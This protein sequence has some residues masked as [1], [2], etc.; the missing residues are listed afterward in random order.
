MHSPAHASWPAAF[1]RSFRKQYPRAVRGEK[2]WLYD[3]HGKQYL[4]LAGSAAVSFLGHGDPEI[5]RAIAAQLGELEF[6]HSSQFA[7]AVAE[8]FAR[9][10]LAFA[11]PAFSG[12]AVYFT[13]GGSEAVETALKLA[14]QYQVES[15]H[16]E[17]FQIISRSQSYHGATFGA[18][19]VS[20]NLRR[21]QPYLPML[22]EFGHINTPYCY[23]CAYGGNNCAASYAGELERAIGEAEGK[24]AAFICEP[25]SGATL[26]AVAPPDG[27]LQEVRRICDAHGLLWIA[28]EVMTGCGRTGRNFACEHW[29]VAPD[30]I[31]AGKGLASGYAPLGAVIASHDV[32][33]AIAVGS[34]SLIHGFTFNAHPVS[35]AAGRAVLRRIRELRLV[36]AADGGN[37]GS[38]A[39]EFAA[40]L[41]T[42][43]DCDCVGDVRGL[44][45]L[46]GVE[47]VADR[48]TK[49][50][51]DPSAGF[52]ARIF[53]AAQRRGVLV[54]PMQGSVDGVRGDHLL[55]APPAITTRAE[56][57]R[58]ISELRHAI[59]EAHP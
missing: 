21:R 33:E 7:T 16:D 51:L 17:R 36:E 22:R 34:G 23:R 27:Y 52:A 41:Q 57:H 1:P 50:P 3:E 26:G 54:Y 59:R 43:R 55:L 39:A 40:A 10:L 46:W 5:A 48:Q 12:G 58:G 4:D 2:A 56:I 38:L 29:R 31:V 8:D 28:D 32:V 25:I 24:A 37:P 18:M 19:A 11:G 44:G 35:V 14:R 6:A 45:L 53:D 49:A 15:G 9:E 20:G 47:F 42:L 13:S 30:I